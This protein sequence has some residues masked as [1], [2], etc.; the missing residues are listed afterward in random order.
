MG[1]DLLLR[2]KGDANLCRTHTVARSIGLV[3]T[4][5]K[6]LSLPVYGGGGVSVCS[7]VVRGVSML[8][9]PTESLLF[10]RTSLASSPPQEPQD[11]ITCGCGVRNG[12]SQTAYVPSSPLLW[13][14]SSSS[15]APL[16]CPPTQGSNHIICGEGVQSG[17]LGLSTHFHFLLRA[18][19][20]F[21]SSRAPGSTTFLT[22]IFVDLHRV[23][24][25]P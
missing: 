7:G 21:S 17:L 16:P 13:Y 9:P 19:T 24:V 11:L 8:P 14:H 23:V 6:R 4:A 20:S 22:L 15:H 1:L 5:G 2:P 10:L 18:I 3:S 25:R 12:L